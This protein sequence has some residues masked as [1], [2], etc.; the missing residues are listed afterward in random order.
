MVSVVHNKVVFL[1]RLK[2]PVRTPEIECLLGVLRVLAGVLRSKVVPDDSF[3]VVD[4][5]KTLR[6][7]P[8][9]PV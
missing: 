7:T 4:A 3:I 5:G 9:A 8:D 1:V 2:R 6:R